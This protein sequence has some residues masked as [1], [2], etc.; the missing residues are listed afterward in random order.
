MCHSIIGVF[1]CALRVQGWCNTPGKWGGIYECIWWATRS[2]TVEHRKA[3]NVKNLSGRYE[4]YA[5]IRK[6]NNSL[7]LIYFSIKHLIQVLNYLLE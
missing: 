4:M 3:E 6:E 1:E 5:A 2:T 7:T